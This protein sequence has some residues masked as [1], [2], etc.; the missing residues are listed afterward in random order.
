MRISPI[1]MPM[2]W[3][4]AMEADVVSSCLIDIC[5]LDTENVMKQLHLTMSADPDA[6][7]SASIA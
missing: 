4:R 3:R 5:S 2:G 6:I 7:K 1:P